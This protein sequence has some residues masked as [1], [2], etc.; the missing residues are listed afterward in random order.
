MAVFRKFEASKQDRFVSPGIPG[1]PKPSLIGK[2]LLIKG[3]VRASEEIVIEGRI[4]GNLQVKH[5]VIVGKS[6]IVKADIEANEVIIQGRVDGHVKAGMKVEIFPEGVLNGNIV[7][8]RVVLAEG[9][10]LKGSIDMSV[11]EEKKAAS[12]VIS[13]REGKEKK[14]AAKK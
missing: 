12:E 9:A 7:S 4:E 1:E 13:D 8:Q 5:R 14:D 3:R 11:R 10:I 6:G 2:T